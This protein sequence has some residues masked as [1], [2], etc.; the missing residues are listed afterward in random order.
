M[1]FVIEL[2]PNELSHLNGYKDIVF[3][4]DK[5]I[6]IGTDGRIDNI[7]IHGEKL[8][9]D[10]SCQYKLNSAFSN[11][12][13]FIAVGEHG[14]IIYSTDGNTFIRAESGTDKNISGITFKNG[15]IIAGAEDGALLTSRDA[16]VWNLIKTK[17]QGN[18]LSLSSN[19]S[20]FIG[21]TDA[22][23]IIKSTDGVKWEIRDYNKEYAGYNPYSKFKKILAVDNNIF[24]IGTHE[25]GSPSILFSSLGNV[26]A[27][28]LPVYYD[29][30]GSVNYLI[31]EPNDITYDPDQDQFILAC[32]KGELFTLP[33]CSKCNKLIKISESDL[34]AII[35][36]NN[37]LLI[38][39]AD[40]SVFIQRL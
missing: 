7:S 3:F 30:K 8:T 14:L 32:E 12:N 6:A 19:N 15:L 9:I 13:L 10:S 23:E 26:W 2:I 21:V 11:V 17:A 5:Y 37:F 33:G 31:S 27:E 22:G 38:G 24:I 16:K 40:Y 29:D 20:L 4:R 18:I 28:R 39:D 1:L 35:Y 34:S 25:D 36:Y